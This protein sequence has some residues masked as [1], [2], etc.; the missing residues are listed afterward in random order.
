MAET[1]E[2]TKAVVDAARGTSVNDAL[3][4]FGDPSNH[5]KVREHMKQAGVDPDEHGTALTVIVASVA[6]SC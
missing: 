1:H 6:F 4:F 2:H 3:D 5:D